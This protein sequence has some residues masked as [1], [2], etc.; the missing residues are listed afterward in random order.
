MYKYL[1]T[2]GVMREFIPERNLTNVTNMVDPLSA[3]QAWVD[4]RIYIEWR[5]R[6]KACGKAFVKYSHLWSH[7]GIHTAKKPHQRM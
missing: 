2:F 5:Y 7:K 1:Y 6:C 3:V 4:T